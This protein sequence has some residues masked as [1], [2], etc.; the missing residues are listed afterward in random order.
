[1]TDFLRVLRE[2][3]LEVQQANSFSLQRSEM[4]IDQGRQEWRAAEGCYVPGLD[5]TQISPEQNI[6][7]RW[8]AEKNKLP[9]YRHV[10]PPEVIC[11][12]TQICITTERWVVRICVLLVEMLRPPR[13]SRNQTKGKDVS[14]K[15]AKTAKKIL[16]A[17]EIP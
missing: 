14:R 4:F 8:G 3:N 7:P 11:L 17:K 15:D 13:P 16:P 6:A 12:A 2:F 5:S 1:M 9:Y 10:P